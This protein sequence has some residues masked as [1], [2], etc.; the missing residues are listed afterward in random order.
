[1]E[2]AGLL[3]GGYDSEVLSMREVKKAIEEIQP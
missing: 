3:R 2:D 1:M